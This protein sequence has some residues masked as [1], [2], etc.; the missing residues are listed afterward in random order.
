MVRRLPAGETFPALLS[1]LADNRRGLQLHFP[2]SPP[3]ILAGALVEVV[4]D[5]AIYLGEIR[6]S[7]ESTV[8]VAV[9]HI[10]D[11]AVLGEIERV[12]RRAEV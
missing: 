7:T 2:A 1:N 8:A 11:R 9:E 6:S 12:W 10:L 3:D 4:S 5:S